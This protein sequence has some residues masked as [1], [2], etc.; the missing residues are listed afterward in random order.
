MIRKC[1]VTLFLFLFASSGVCQEQGYQTDIGSSPSHLIFLELGGH[2]LA[3]INYEKYLTKHVGV[4]V[5]VGLC[6]P[7][8]LNYYIGNE[9]LLELGVGLM[10][11]PIALKP[12]VLK[13]K[14]VLLGCTI[15]HKFQ[16]NRG[17]LS[18][19]YSFTPMFNPSNGKFVPMFGLS[20]GFAFL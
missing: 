12:F 14:T 2:G 10:Y 15:G 3:S 7:L 16:P 1:A 17:G 6:F 19:R 13:E 11:S 5:G 8:L 9:R 20:A 4:R 18:L